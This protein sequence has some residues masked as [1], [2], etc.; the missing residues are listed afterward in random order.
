[1]IDLVAVICTDKAHCSDS[2]LVTHIKFS[3]IMED[4]ETRI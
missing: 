4:I 1:M 2:S 3:Q